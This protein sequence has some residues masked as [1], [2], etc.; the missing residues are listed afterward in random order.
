[1]SW[2]STAFPKRTRSSSAHA[3]P[4]TL[5]FANLAHA[6]NTHVR[7]KP[8]SLIWLASLITSKPLA[9]SYLFRQLS[10]LTLLQR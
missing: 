5:P 10:C 8:P 3:L 1:M 7:V 2:F 4:L 9:V 6:L